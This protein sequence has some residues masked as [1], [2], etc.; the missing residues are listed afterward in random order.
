MSVAGAEGL[1]PQE[2]AAELQAGG[3]LVVFSYAV[4]VC[5]LTFGQDSRPHLVRKGES[6][7]F[8]GLP[9]TLLTLALGWWGF[10][11]GPIFTIAALWNNLSGGEDVTDRALGRGP[12]PPPPKPDD[13]DPRSFWQRHKDGA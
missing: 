7:F 3:R 4:S 1:S 12:G 9:Y 10:P 8:K 13:D 6:A 5:V 2:L 11:F